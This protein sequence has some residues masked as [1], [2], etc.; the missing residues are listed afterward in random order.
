MTIRRT[1]MMLRMF[2]TLCFVVII[3]YWTPPVFSAPPVK[4]AS[5]VGTPRPHMRTSAISFRSSNPQTVDDRPDVSR[6]SPIRLAVQTVRLTPVTVDESVSTQSNADFLKPAPMNDM[7]PVLSRAP[8]YVLR[9]ADAV[10]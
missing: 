2:R 3:C 10:R 6:R 7:R 1:A 4:G 5:F 8:M 9:V